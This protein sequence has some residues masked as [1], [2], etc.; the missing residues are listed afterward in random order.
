M[1]APY[2]GYRALRKVRWTDVLDEPPIAW[3]LCRTWHIFH[4]IG[5][6]IEKKE[7]EKDAKEKEKKGERK[8]RGGNKF[9]FQ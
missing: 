9:L 3:N 6:K 4:A 8:G 7:K 2:V 1:I 5:R